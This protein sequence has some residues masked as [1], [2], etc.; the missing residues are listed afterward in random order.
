MKRK[1]LSNDEFIF[2]FFEYFNL[3]NSL[4]I[5]QY[6][7]I[8]LSIYQYKSISMIWL[9]CQI[10]TNACQISTTLYQFGR[11]LFLTKAFC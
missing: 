7:Y 1:Y 3:T 11:D 5:Y 2:E 8:N 4:S 9:F 10:L 6:M